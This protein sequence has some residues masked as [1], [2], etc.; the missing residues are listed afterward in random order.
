[1]KIAKLYI[2]FVILYLLIVPYAHSQTD[3]TKQEVKKTKDYKFIFGFDSRISWVLDTRTR[4]NGVKIGVEYMGKD[5]VGLGFYGVKNPIIIKDVPTIVDSVPMFNGFDTVLVP[6]LDTLN[7]LTHYSYITIFLDHIFISK[8]KW[9]LSMP[10]QLG[11]GTAT[12]D[13]TNP[14]TAKRVEVVKFGFLVTE[15]SIAGHYKFFSWIGVGTGLGY[16]SMITKD[17]QVKK[18]FDAPIIVFKLKIFLGDLYRGIF[19]KK[20]KK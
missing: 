20:E 2:P 15:I 1:M 16:R 9:E 4:F 6:I 3:T 12:I 7:Y 8:R 5:R 10:L 18:A 14:V 13:Y 17:K 19:P 11:A